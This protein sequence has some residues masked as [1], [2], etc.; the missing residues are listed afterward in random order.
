MFF[1]INFRR[2]IDR[3]LLKNLIQ[4]ARDR[5]NSHWSACG[6]ALIIAERLVE[7]GVSVLLGAHMS[8][9]LHKRLNPKIKFS[10]ETFLEEDDTYLILEYQNDE[11]WGK[12]R[13]LRANSYTLHSDIYNSPLNFYPKFSSMIENFNPRLLVISGEQVL[14]S[15][16]HLYQIQA[17]LKNIP[18]STLV[19]FKL[20]VEQIFLKQLLDLIVPYSDSLSMNEQSFSNLQRFYEIKSSSSSFQSNNLVT[21]TLDDLRT[22]FTILYD[23]SGERDT[24]RKV[25]RIHFNTQDFQIIVTDKSFGWRNAKQ[26]I[27]K[28][29]L[30]A[31]K[32]V[33]GSE[34]LN[35]GSFLLMV[36]SEFSSSHKPPIKKIVIKEND[37]VPC[38]TERLKTKRDVVVDVEFCVV[39]NLVCRNAIK[40]SGLDENVAATALLLQI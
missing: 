40:T 33:C 34:I 5:K 27:A 2:S 23:G 19:H 11:T 25:S 35:P 21:S 30:R 16:S 9:D 32:H 36:D 39:P 1:K 31:A 26:S 24:T 37:V 38:W 7:D 29:S 14:K 28:A 8:K 12:L 13:S 22:I 3:H 18:T 17:Q 15:K 20:P 4:R 6:S 10:Q